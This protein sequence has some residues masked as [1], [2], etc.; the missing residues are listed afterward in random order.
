M[1][2]AAERLAALI[3]TVAIRDARIPV[4]ANVTAAPVERAEEIRHLLVEQVA[5]PV[6]WV[7]SVERM[8]AD[9][10]EVFV[11][12]GP[13]TVLSGLIKRSAAGVRTLHVEDQAS[14]AEALSAFAAA[15][16]RS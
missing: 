14:L 7:Q 4:V 6:R 9:G 5:T 15:S 8:V 1:R 13:G 10:V 2:P 11:E 3:E 12:L 16:D